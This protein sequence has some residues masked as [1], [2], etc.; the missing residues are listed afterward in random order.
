MAVAKRLLVLI[1]FT[2]LGS[3]PSTVQARN[4]STPSNLRHYFSVT[5]Q[6]SGG[7]CSRPRYITLP[8]RSHVDGFYILIKSNLPVQFLLVT[9]RTIASIEQETT[10]HFTMAGD[11]SAAVSD[12]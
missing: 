7:N 1:D 9:V 8:V 6:S 12:I 10:A 3:S 2:P 11:K 4:A 5:V